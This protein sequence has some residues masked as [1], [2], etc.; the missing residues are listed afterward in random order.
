[1]IVITFTVSITTITTIWK[2]LKAHI[3]GELTGKARGKPTRRALTRKAPYR[4]STKNPDPK[5]KI[6][7]PGASRSKSK[8]AKGLASSNSSISST[9]TVAPASDSHSSSVLYA[10]CLWH[11][12]SRACSTPGKVLGLLLCDWACRQRPRLAQIRL[13]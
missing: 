6:Q 7:N 4:E 12:Q 1:M 8:T 13:G 10:L 5:P 9:G 2:A 3:T 11:A